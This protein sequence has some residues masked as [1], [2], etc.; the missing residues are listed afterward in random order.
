MQAID[1]GSSRGQALLRHRATRLALIENPRGQVQRQPEDILQLLVVRNLPANIADGA[2]KIGSE[3]AQSLARPLEL[4]GMG[5]ALV[6]DQRE[7]A[8]PCAAL[9]QVKP[10]L[11]GK[12]HQLLAGEV[13]GVL[14]PWGTSRSSA[15]PWYRRLRG[16][17][18][19][20]CHCSSPDRHRE[21]FLQECCNPLLTHPLPP[22][23]Q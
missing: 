8:H 12:R 22:A 9:A 20:R 21:T 1:P 7:L 23:R 17:R 19:L 11:P 10:C 6:F 3:L 2:A 14:H 4:F 13:A 16:P 15:A 18:I 5:V